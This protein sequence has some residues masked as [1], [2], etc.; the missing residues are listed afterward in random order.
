ML[1]IVCGFTSHQ[2]SFSNSLCRA[3]LGLN[4]CNGNHHYSFYNS[5]SNNFKIN[6]I[7]VEINHYNH[8]YQVLQPVKKAIMAKGRLFGVIAFPKSGL[9]CVWYMYVRV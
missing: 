8:R 6:V 2:Y 5:N 9:I 7:V 3:V 4:D 1:I